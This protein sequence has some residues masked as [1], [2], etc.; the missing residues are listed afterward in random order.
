MIKRYQTKEMKVIWSEE[1]KYDTW[2]KVELLVCDAW[3]NLGLIDKSDLKKLKKVKVDLKLMNSLE[4]QTQ[5][6][7][8]AFTRMLSHSLEN[9]KRWIHLG[10]TSTDVVDTA[11]NYLIKQANDVIAKEL[12]KLLDNLKLKALKYRNLICIGRTHGIFAEP[13]SFGLKFVLWYEEI[14]RQVERFLL[15]RKQIEV[16]KISGAVGNYANVEP[17]VEDFV[18]QELELG[19]DNISTQVTQ[20]DR[21]AFLFSVFA[22]IASTLEK[23]ALEIR[24][25]QR[26]EV[27]EIREGFSLNQKGSSAMPHKQN[28]IG[29]ENI[30]GL[31]RLIRANSVVAYEN[32]LLWNE[33]DISHSS[34]ERIII[35]GTFSLLHFIL[36]RMNAI[37]N[38]LEVNEKNIALNIEKTFNTFFSQRLLLE[39]IKKTQF[40]REEI[41]DFLQE[42]TFASL[43]EKR[44]FKEVV[45]EYKISKYLDDKQLEKCFD[46]NYFVRNVNIIYERVFPKRE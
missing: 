35:S 38:L 39:I 5:H 46:I 6:D 24:H 16:I 1:K 12:Q 42:C 20:R 3:G 41:Y 23:I 44:D 2:L 32:N 37:L 22:N 4:K 26:S 31:A 10:L 34:N 11:Q 45:K 14:N 9:E 17:V 40:S 25:S 15:A 28:P 18:R 7:M 19:V 29:S 21:H 27:D 33:R 30:C 43:K 8:V 36:K 13:T